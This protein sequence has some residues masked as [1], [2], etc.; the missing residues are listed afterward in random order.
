MSHLKPY[1]EATALP[2]HH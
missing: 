2:Q 1:I